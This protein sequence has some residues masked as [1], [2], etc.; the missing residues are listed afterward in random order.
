MKRLRGLV[1]FAAVLGFSSAVAAQCGPDA[2]GTSRTLTVNTAGGPK[3]GTKHYPATLDLAD[4]ELVLT[5]D[6]G[7][8]SGTTPRVLEAL[9]RECVKA[10]FFLIGRNAAG[11]PQLVARTAREGHSIAN[12]TQNHPWTIDK[13]S[14]ER[15][16]GE[17]DTGAASI[18]AALGGA[19]RLA[20]F[21]RFPGFV[22]TP[23]LL[24]ELA[25]RNVATFGADLWAS[26]WDPMTPDVQLRQV[27]AR[28][29]K[30]RRGIVLFHDTREQTAAMLPAF[31]RELKRRGY[32]IVHVVGA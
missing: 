5:F 15:G 14:Y 30:A 21:V 1:F 20:P 23:A 27:L 24:S 18:R 29:E 3:F 32:R 26:D 2:L 6:D 31:L 19:G 17:I 22:E 8:A 13:L 28:V 9:A 10:T 4:R 7:P 11:L 25:R 12:H 16:L